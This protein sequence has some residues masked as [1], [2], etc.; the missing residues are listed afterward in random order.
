M[1]VAQNFIMAFYGEPYVYMPVKLQ[2]HPTFQLSGVVGGRSVM[3][4]RDIRGLLSLPHQMGHLTE[5]SLIQIK[6]QTTGY[7]S[8]YKICF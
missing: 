6:I 1:E 3:P 8:Q 4:H 5:L 2:A 7:Q